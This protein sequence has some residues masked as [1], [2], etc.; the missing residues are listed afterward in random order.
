[1]YPTVPGGGGET[2]SPDEVLGG[3]GKNDDSPG[4]RCPAAAGMVGGGTEGW[5]RYGGREAVG[6]SR[7]SMQKDRLYEK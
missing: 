5:G 2:P 1:M 6:F 7:E 4:K 3:G